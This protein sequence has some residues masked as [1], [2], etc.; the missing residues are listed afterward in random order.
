VK[1]RDF[2]KSISLGSAGHLGSQTDFHLKNVD[3]LGFATVHPNSWL[4]IG[5]RGESCGASV[6]RGAKLAL[7]STQDVFDE[8]SAPGL[9]REPGYLHSDLFVDVDARDEPGY[10]TSGGRYRVSV[11]AYHDQTYSRYSF[12]RVEADAEQYIPLLHKS[13]VLALHGRMAMSQTSAGQE[14]PFYLLQPWRPTTLPKFSDY[15]FRD[16][17]VLW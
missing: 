1:Y 13:W 16:R 2:R 8:S 12:R 9:T 4:S 7:P 10:P 6:S 11:G 3:V 17:N 14:V 15:R 5:G